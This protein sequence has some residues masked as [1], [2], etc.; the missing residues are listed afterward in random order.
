LEEIGRSIAS[1]ADEV[2]PESTPFHAVEGRSPNPFVC[3]FLRS[4]DGAGRLA[5]PVEAADER[6]RCA[7]LGDP[8]PQT[9]RQQELA[10]LGAG[11]ADCPRYLRGALLLH[12]ALPAVPAR[13]ALTRATLAAIMV[14]VASATL[15]FGAVLA[16][17][18]LTLPNAPLPAAT[19]VAA[20]SPTPRATIAPS[21]APNP[22][23]I[24][25]PTLAPTPA[26]TNESAPVPT[27]EPTA[28]PTPGPT[29]APIAVPTSDRYAYLEPCPDRPNCWIYVAR[30]GNSLSSI[31]TFFGVPFSTV[32]QMNPQLGSPPRLWLGDKV[33]IPT[34][35]L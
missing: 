20:G 5:A 16:R 14:L 30:R 28:A 7:A 31:S 27:L 1:P 9:A 2:R 32:V 29:A 25:A 3:L 34:P 23:P 24:P 11:H 22:A 21:T 18:G 33:Y 15:S 26:P 8:S 17:G 10:C 35:R 6:N 19:D 12:Q 4:V 13:R